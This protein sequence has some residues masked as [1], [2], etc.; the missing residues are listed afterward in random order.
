MLCAWCGVGDGALWMCPKC[1]EFKFPVFVEKRKER[2]E[3]AE[4]IE[5]VERLED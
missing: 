1:I 2:A 3:L 5:R 4:F